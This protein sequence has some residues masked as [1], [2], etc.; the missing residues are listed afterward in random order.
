MLLGMGR[1]RPLSTLLG[2][3]VWF[4]EWRFTAPDPSA[5]LCLLSAPW[6]VIE[7]LITPM[8][9]HLLTMIVG[10]TTSVLSTVLR[11]SIHSLRVIHDDRSKFIRQCP[12]Q[13]GNSTAKGTTPRDECRRARI[14][15]RND[16][17]ALPFRV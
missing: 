2:H 14:I 9:G 1:Y 11:L 13:F 8:I 16:Y 6:P 10:G 17:V 7:D 12:V 4:D 3:L 5:R 15:G